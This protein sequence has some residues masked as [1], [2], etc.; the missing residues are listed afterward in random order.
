ML[1]Y[2]TTDEIVNPDGVGRRQ[3]FQGA[4][5]Y[6]RLNEAYAIGGAIRDKWN[7]MGAE[8]GP[9]GYP[10]T[11]E[12]GGGKYNGRFNDFE[13]GVIAWSSATNAHAMF[14]VFRDKWNTLRR[15]NGP[16]GY[17]TSDEFVTPNN[18]GRGL[19][20]EGGSIY[21]LNGEAPR[22][23]GGIIRDKW[24]QAG[25]ET[26]RYRFP[27]GEEY[28]LDGGF[29][30][31]FEGGILTRDLGE[32]PSDF[33]P[34]TGPCPDYICNDGRSV[35]SPASANHVA[36]TSIADA[37]TCDE[38]A[39]MPAGGPAVLCKS[40]R[41]PV[42]P[43]ERTS[44]RRASDDYIVR[45]ICYDQAGQAWTDR[46]Y[47]CLVGSL[48]FDVQRRGSTE[49]TGT[50][51]IFVE[52]D[53]QVYWDQSHADWTQRVTIDEVTGEMVGSNYS[54]TFTCYQG[55]VCSPQFSQPTAEILQQGRVYTSQGEVGFD[56]PGV[57]ELTVA[58]MRLGFEFTP[59][60]EQN[61]TPDVQPTAVQYPVVRCDQQ[62]TEGQVGCVYTSEAPVLT[63]YDPYRHGELAGHISAAQQT[64]VAGSESGDP[65]TKGTREAET[66]NRDNACKANPRVPSPR[67]GGLDCDEYPFASTEQ[68]AGAWTVASE[69]SFVGCQLPS[70][71]KTVT[72][73]GYSIC[74]IDPAQN[75]RG[76]S[77]LRWFYHHNR[78]L[79]YDPFYVAA[80]GGSL[81][82]GPN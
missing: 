11:D 13:N 34:P 49:V 1:G 58:D 59:A 60:P 39:K 56:A 61:W 25:W 47:S 31:D 3:E 12:L 74:L 42:N 44:Q 52:T 7:T 8:A 36:R 19:H 48:A 16:L 46:S 71:S 37:P 6:W 50:A 29:A 30:Q 54:S 20:L 2:P 14:G 26:G 57:G 21:S 77:D 43:L 35:T 45:S 65:L 79:Q 63:Y 70:V 62:L 33:D 40:T 78:V 24:S 41:Q 73:P 72:G 55:P 82:N 23:V 53:A 5:I 66:E 17:P 15:Q 51:D 69:R 64:G 67:P 9:L 38:V 81:P 22:A 27:I 4:A 75:R 18:R 80:A 28:P 32:Q 76:G 68:G 10:R